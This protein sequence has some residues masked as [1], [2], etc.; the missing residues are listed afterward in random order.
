MKPAQI[1][2]EFKNRSF[3]LYLNSLLLIIIAP[4]ILYV[5][6][7]AFSGFGFYQINT[8]Y[9]LNIHTISKYLLFLSF[10]IPTSILVCSLICGLDRKLISLIF[11]TLVNFIIYGL[12]IFFFTTGILTII[13]ILF[14]FN[15]ILGLR[16]TYIIIG[17]FLITGFFS[18]IGPIS[19]GLKPFLKKDYIPIIGARLN[20]KDHKKI[21]DKILEICKNIK[22]SPPKNIIV[23][24]TTEFFAV[25]DKLKVFNGIDQKI[26]KGNSIYISLPFL[27]TLTINEFATI[28]GHE[29]GHF[30]GE[31]TL[32]SVKF[33]PI[34]RKLNNQ[35]IS[36]E[37]ERKRN[38]FDYIGIY[39]II[40]LYNEFTRKEEKISKIQELEAD[41]FGSSAANGKTYASALAKLYIY[42]L[43]W[44]RTKH[45]HREIVR[46]KL[47]INIKNLSKD[48]IKLSRNSLDKSRLT[49]LLKHMLN[50]EQKHPNDTHPPLKERMKNLKVKEK[51]ITNKDLINFLP[52]ASSLISNV[53]IIE[54]NLTLIESEI[55]KRKFKIG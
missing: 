44:E 25:S 4:L 41:Q 7:P 24:L 43:V 50:Y 3:V 48:F 13:S 27:R 39:P 22:A 46:D 1:S 35:F 29:V 34:Y 5:I 55:E 33:A 10:L 42:D 37:K 26:I 15:E 49:E 21:F 30:V 31:D 6:I 47:K 32:Y 18:A 20:K 9:I 38:F 11:P 28:I 17:F 52:S 12:V 45:N 23:G 40:F 8:T 19:K 14:F 53:E 51:D 54:E 36:L 16:L 2:K